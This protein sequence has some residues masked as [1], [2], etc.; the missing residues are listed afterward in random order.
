MDEADGN[1]WCCIRAL[2]QAARKCARRKRARRDAMAFRLREGEELLALAG[3]LASGTYVPE[4]GRVFVTERPKYREVHAAAYRDRVVHHLLHDLLEPVFEPRLSEASFACRKGKGTHAA[5][6]RLQQHMWKLSRHGGVRLFALSMDIANF[7][8]SLHRPTL[9]ELLRPHAGNHP[10][11]T[12]IERLIRHDHAGAAR[13]ICAA[14]L[15]ALVPPH[16]RLGA[17][18]PEHGLPIG[19]LTSQFFANVYLS[20]L[21]LFVQRRLGIRGYVRYVD[22]FV[23]LDASAERLAEAADRI[24]DFLRERLRLGVRAKPIRPVSAGVDFVGYIVRPRYLLPRRRVVRQLEAKLE[25]IESSHRPIV[26]PHGGGLTLLGLGRVRGPLR[27]TRIDETVCERLRATWASYEGHLA[28]ASAWRLR[29]DIWRRHPGI[30]GFLRRSHGK[31]GRRFALV[32]PCD[33][34]RS[35]VAR[36]STGIAGSRTVLV[37]KV[38][39]FA[40]VPRGHGRFGLR[41]SRRVAGR[42]RRLGVLWRFASGLVERIL[43]AGH[44]VAVALEQSEWCGNVKRRYLAYLFEPLESEKEEG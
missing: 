2:A 40:Q 18:G 39:R 8:M 6:A 28:K 12:T 34:F 5:A 3:R 31:I 27:C 19:N 15:F 43:R 30:H 29:R 26:V 14:R 20:P 23:L 7:F 9:L 42:G 25:E 35:Q 44:P 32:R 13:P 16:K 38:G 1:S 24:V 36:L 11:W 4:P 37:V 17:L 33:S 10:A 21:D 22:D 41:L